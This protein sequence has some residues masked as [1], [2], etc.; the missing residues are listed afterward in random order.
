MKQSVNSNKLEDNLLRK[1]SF[2]KSEKLPEDDF[3]S[4]VCGDSFCPR[5][6]R[7]LERPHSGEWSRLCHECR[8]HHQFYPRQLSQL[9]DL[10]VSD[11]QKQR[12]KMF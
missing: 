1:F 5:T 3:N 8:H 6:W 11:G 4:D 10:A 12:C 7:L 2:S 9:L